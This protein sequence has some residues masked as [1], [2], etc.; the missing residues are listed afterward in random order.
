MMGQFVHVIVAQVCGGHPIAM[1]GLFDGIGS[2]GHA[3]I[4]CGV[5]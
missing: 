5:G 1:G 4:A 3:T 2:C